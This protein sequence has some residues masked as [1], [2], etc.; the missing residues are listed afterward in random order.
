[1]SQLPLSIPL[2]AIVSALPWSSKTLHN[3]RWCGEAEWL[4]RTDAYGKV[5]GRLQ[6]NLPQLIADLYARDRVN[7]IAEV[8][9]RVHARQAEMGAV[10]ISA[11]PTLQQQLQT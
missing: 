4:S 10:L 9:K 7:V 11:A 3:M 8:M 2:A 1:M 5:R 6:V